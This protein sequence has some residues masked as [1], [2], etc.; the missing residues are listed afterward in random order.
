MFVLRE[1][2]AATQDE[3]SFSVVGRHAVGQSLVGSCGCDQPRPVRGCVA[4]Q[5]TQW[6]AC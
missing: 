1:C 5:P 3:T 6:D 4:Q 2:C